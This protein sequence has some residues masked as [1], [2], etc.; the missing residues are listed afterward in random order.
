MYIMKISYIFYIN[1]TAIDLLA[2]LN[3]FKSYI[4]FNRLSPQ[5]N[6]YHNRARSRWGAIANPHAKVLTPGHDLGNRMKIL[7]DMF[8]IFYLWEY[9]QSL[10]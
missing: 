5:I 3:C 1:W 6:Y 2:P 9:T 8:S 7:F 10:V 4:L